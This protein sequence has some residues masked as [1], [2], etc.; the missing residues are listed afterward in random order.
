V[1]IVRVLNLKSP[2][3]W[4]ARYD[5]INAFEKNLAENNVIL[6]K[7]FLHISK[8][9]QAER[10]NARI[11]DPRKNWKFQPED[12]KMREKWPQF[13]M[14]YE[15]ALNS[16]STPYAPWHLIPANRKW[17]RDFVVAKTVVKALED[18]KLK[19]PKPHKDLKKFRITR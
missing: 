9:E 10:L 6:L 7:F 1:L 19:W 18:L 11:N 8:E 17:F 3:V 16:C 13:M 2:A 5:Q 14:A 15:D 12:L 4:Q